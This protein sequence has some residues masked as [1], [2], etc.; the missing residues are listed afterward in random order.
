[1]AIAEHHPSEVSAKNRGVLK[2]SHQQLHD[3]ASTSE[4]HL[5]EKK[6]H[7]MKEYESKHEDGLG[8]HGH[9]AEHHTIKHTHIEHH[10]DGSRTMH[11]YHH[12][13]AV[14]TKEEGDHSHAV[15]DLDGV[16][17]NLEEHV[18]EPNDDEAAEAA[19][20]MGGQGE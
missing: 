4:K 6:E 15:P 8:H 17:D 18:G 2:M 1:M 10:D 14:P 19:G 9:S 3:F 16:H 12:P 13:V 5:P 20:A 7:S 11:H